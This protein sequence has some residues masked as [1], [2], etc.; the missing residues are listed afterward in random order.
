MKPRT[1][2]TSV[3]CFLIASVFGQT[4]NHYKVNPGQKI[5]DAIPASEVYSY[6]EF[7][8]GKVYLRNNTVSAVKL[9]Y[10]SVLAEMQF[11]NP[12][13]DTLSV[14]D[15]KMISIILVGTD[16][17][18]YDNVYLRL[19]SHEGKIKLAHS[20][21]FEMSNRE[22]AGE[23]GQPSGGSVQTYTSMSSVAS[24]TSTKPLV[25]NEFLTMAKRSVYYIGDEFNSFKVAN[26]KN[27]LEMYSK[28][29]NEVKTYLKEKKVDFNKE[30]DLKQLIIFL[31]NITPTMPL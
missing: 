15:E 20:Q 13:G 18:Y 9:N 30:E 29:E 5:T 12:K 1:I 26:K 21:Y 27:V 23:F 3:C 22:K 19:V 7:T 2:L 8:P 10:N 14:A 31:K 4:R 24:Q 17:F 28:N 11:I 16:T 25:A 6:P